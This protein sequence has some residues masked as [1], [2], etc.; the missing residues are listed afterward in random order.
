LRA[1]RAG[2]DPGSTVTAGNSSGQNDGDPMCIVTTLA[3]EMDRRQSRYG[4]ETMCIGG[5]QGL[6]AISE[7]VAS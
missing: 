6:A 3:R 2:I 1:I 4:L 7:R 5:G